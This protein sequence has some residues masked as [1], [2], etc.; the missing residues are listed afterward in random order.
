VVS[1]PSCGRSVTEF[2]SWNVHRRSYVVPMR[3]MVIYEYEILGW[4]LT[5]SSTNLPR[6]WS[7]WESSPTRKNS[8]GGTVNRT[9]DPT[10]SSKQLWPLDHEAGLIINVEQE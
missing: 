1:S 3:W 2:W 4:A 5:L 7:P 9:R 6:P 8:H 10:I